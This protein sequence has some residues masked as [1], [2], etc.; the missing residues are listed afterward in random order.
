METFVVRK[1]ILLDAGNAEV[2]D[3]LTNPEKTKEYFFNCRVIS[4][5]KPGSSITFKG[6][7]F[8]IIPI[9]LKGTIEKI[10]PK[11]LLQYK[12][13]NK[14]DK[15]GFSLVTDSL[16]AQNGKTLLRISDDVGQGA[17]AEKRFRKSDK[18]WDKVLNGLKKLVEN[19]PD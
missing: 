15:S 18:G 8:W 13:Y 5:W 3:A 11:E 19:N 12:L 14:S 1:Q 9:T 17:G 7:I 4:D 16:T 2:W 6:K 10:V